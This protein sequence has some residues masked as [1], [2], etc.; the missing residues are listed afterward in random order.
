LSQ[1]GQM[2]SLLVFWLAAFCWQK[3]LLCTVT[4]FTGMPFSSE[5][6]RYSEFVIRYGKSL[7]MTRSVSQASRRN[8]QTPRR[9]CN[10]YSSAKVGS[11]VYRPNG[12]VKCL[13]THQVSN[14]NKDAFQQGFH[15]SEVFSD[16]ALFFKSEIL[17]PCQSS[18]RSCHPIWTPIYPLF[19]PFG[20]RVTPSWRLDRSSIIC[21]DDVHSCPDLHCF[22]KLLLQLASV[23]TFQ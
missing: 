12:I 22:E 6:S 14:I 1:N 11:Q 20:R 19:H 10:I 15:Y 8:F 16:F 17:V 18:R 4:A 5:S 23:Q 13:D 21:Q 3:S 9:L 7:I 2:G